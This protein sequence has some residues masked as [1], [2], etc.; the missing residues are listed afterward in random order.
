M[1]LEIPEAHDIVGLLSELCSM[2]P[3]VHDRILDEHDKMRP[4]VNVFVNE[5]NIRDLQH[6]RTKVKDGDEVYVLPSV[7]GGKSQ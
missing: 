6:E 5:E 7:A 3:L 2:F 4:Y 1:D